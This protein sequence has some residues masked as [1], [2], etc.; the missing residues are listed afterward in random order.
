[1][2]THLAKDLRAVGLDR[3]DA[4]AETVGDLFGHQSLGHQLADLMLARGEEIETGTDFAGR[5]WG[6]TAWHGSISVGYGMPRHVLRPKSLKIRRLG[7]H[8]F[9]SHAFLALF[10]SRNDRDIRGP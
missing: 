3:I 2:D 5:W 4:R 7:N 8:V 6:F 1:M 9:E 10:P